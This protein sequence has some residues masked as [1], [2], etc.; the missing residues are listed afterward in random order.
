M[1]EDKDQTISHLRELV[2]NLTAELNVIRSSLS[3]V[4][5]ELAELKQIHGSIDANV[6]MEEWPEQEGEH[7]LKTRGI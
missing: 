4:E 7:C 6:L 5:K 2:F 3:I 1:D